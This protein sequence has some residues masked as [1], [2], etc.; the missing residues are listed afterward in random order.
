MEATRG[1][2][3]LNNDFADH[4]LRPLGHVASLTDNYIWGWE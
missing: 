4:R 2:E 3:P 1:F